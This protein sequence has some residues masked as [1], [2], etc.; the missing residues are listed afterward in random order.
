MQHFRHDLQQRSQPHGMRLSPSR[1]VFSAPFAPHTTTEVRA[2]GTYLLLLLG[3]LSPMEYPL[4]MGGREVTSEWLPTQGI[5]QT[6]PAQFKTCLT[7][8]QRS[9]APDLSHLNQLCRY[10]TVAYLDTQHVFLPHHFP[11]SWPSHP[12]T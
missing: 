9:P 1:R 10:N 5:L 3:Q 4:C 7:P 6:F 8:T 12:L 11:C 2:W